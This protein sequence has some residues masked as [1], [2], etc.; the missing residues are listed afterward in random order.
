MKTQPRDSAEVK[1]ST[2]WSVPSSPTA[3]NEDVCSAK[4]SK[5]TFRCPTCELTCLKLFNLKRHMRRKHSTNEKTSN[6]TDLEGNLNQGRCICQQCLFKCNR[7]SDL[8]QHLSKLHNVIFRRE[9]V[10][11]E[12]FAGKISTALKT[13]GGKGINIAFF[14]AAL[15]AMSYTI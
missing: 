11:F 12:S 1:V 10:K 5:H 9:T 3:S 4:Q 6:T 15:R 13:S 14:P 8:R 7:I 2:S